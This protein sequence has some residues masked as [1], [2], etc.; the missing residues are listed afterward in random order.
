MPNVSVDTASEHV[1]PQVVALPDG[2]TPVDLVAALAS[3][4]P[5][6]DGEDY[7]VYEHDGEW[8]LASG[9]RA[10]I[11]LDS[12]ELRIVVD[13][14]VQ[15]RAWTGRPGAVLGEAIDRLLLETS[16]L[17]GWVAIQCKVPAGG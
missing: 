3:A 14:V 6:C 1:A 11:E 12:D 16:R 13:G 10:V 9:V 4:L 2:V 15:R 8:M 7:L 5:E 17:F